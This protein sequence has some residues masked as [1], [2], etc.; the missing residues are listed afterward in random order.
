MLGT[1]GLTE[2][3]QDHSENAR[4]LIPYC[5]LPN[6]KLATQETT[7][8]EPAERERAQPEAVKQKF[9]MLTAQLVWAA[10]AWNATP[11]QAARQIVTDLFEHLSNGGTVSVRVKGLE[12]S[13]HTIEVSARR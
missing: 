12:G 13:E 7:M 10:H 3:A 11:E 1:D 4:C 9:A 8:R 2:V 6:E 5:E